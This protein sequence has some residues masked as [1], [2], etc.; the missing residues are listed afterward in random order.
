[1]LG[2]SDDLTDAELD[3]IKNLGKT[4]T[5]VA[6]AFDDDIGAI[7]Q[8]LVALE[9]ESN[10]RFSSVQ[11]LKSFLHP[12]RRIPDDLLAAILLACLPRAGRSLQPSS[13]NLTAK[14]PAV[15]LS[16]VCQRWRKVVLTTPAFWLTIS[17]YPEPYSD[18]ERYHKNW[19]I[20]N[21][22]RCSGSIT[23]SGFVNGNRRCKT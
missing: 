20:L 10:Q 4:R 23:R 16:H 5:D 8:A 9:A 3:N 21:P 11:S 6:R 13:T 19:A 15:V 12:I 22:T 7:E 14:N 18:T 2:T 17:L 1:M